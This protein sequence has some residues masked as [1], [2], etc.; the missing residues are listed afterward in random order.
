[1]AH[2]LVV[3]QGS[4]LRIFGLLMLMWWAVG[5]Y[6]WAAASAPPE[7]TLEY[8]FRPLMTFRGMYMGA[9]PEVR[10]ARARARLERL[11]TSQIALPLE[12]TPFVVDGT[13]GIGLRL[14]DQVLFNVLASDLDAEEGASLE[15]VAQRAADATEAALRAQGTG[16]QW[17]VLA[18]GVGLASLA[19][20][21]AMVVLVGLTRG[22]RALVAFLTLRV[23]GRT[24]GTPAH[25]GWQHVCQ[26]LKR[27]LQLIYVFLVF[28]LC[29]FWLA[30]VLDCFP[31]TEP[32]GAS[33]GTFVVSLVSGFVRGL[34]GAIPGMTTALV[35]LFLT[36]AV[37]ETLGGLF[38]SVRDGRMRVA[39]LH[40]ETVSATQRIV[41]LVVW[42]FGIALAYPFLPLSDSE[43]F[44][45][46]SVMAG[47][48]LTLG[49][50]GVVTQLMS[51]LVLVY[52]RALAVGDFVDIGGTVGVVSELGVLSAKIVDLGN[53]EVTM[54][55]AVLVGNTM[56]NYSRLAGE[57]G[58]LVSTKVT[59]G[60]DA[61][62]RQVHALLIAAATRTEGLRA[63]PAPFVYQRGLSDFYVEY[64]VFAYM[65]QPIKRV[66]VLSALHANIQ[67]E[68]NAAGVQ[69]MSPHFVLQPRQA[70]VA[71]RPTV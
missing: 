36:R 22:Q 51:G 49:S 4:L 9:S 34:S 58:A 67:D 70:V 21:V 62:W 59:I 68:F 1:M 7:V 61:P 8:N 19:T 20:L 53:V 28:G 27:I 23:G 31:Q 48:M 66:S 32:L 37:N 35:I 60:Y 24:T 13:Q 14:G 17:R 52:S 16:R 69:I 54:P 43:A 55:N 12:Q 64:E 63:A 33:L 6:A 26:L 46:L 2:P 3:R 15:Q 38:Q 42:G 65:D 30:A 50:A 25:H 40:K 44:K 10:A 71:P 39:G 5:G 11:T 41:G 29:Y 56:R 45:G 47:F 18:K 57:R